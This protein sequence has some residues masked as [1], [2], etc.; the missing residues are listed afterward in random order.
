MGGKL[1]ARREGH[2]AYLSFTGAWP[3]D[4][5]AYPDVGLGAR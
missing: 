1:P 4:V 2:L 3:S 5:L